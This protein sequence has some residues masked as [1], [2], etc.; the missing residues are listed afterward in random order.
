MTSGWPPGPRNGAHP[1]VV[2]VHG[3]RRPGPDHDADEPVHPPAVHVRL[4]GEACCAAPRSGAGSSCGTDDRSAPERGRAR[5]R[6]DGRRP[7]DAVRTGIG[8]EVRVER[9]VLL[10]DED[11]VLDAR[12]A[13][14]SGDRS[15]DRSPVDTA[16]PG[17]GATADERPGSSATVPPTSRVSPTASTTPRLILP[18]N[19]KGCPSSRNDGAP[20]ANEGP[21]IFDQPASVFNPR[22]ERPPRN[23][24]RS[25]DGDA[26]V[27]F[28][29]ADA[30][31]SMSVPFVRA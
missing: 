12:L 16:G 20:T 29:R 13:M 4:R 26:S 28:D 9:A 6:R 30:V 27:S 15:A 1:G 18:T 11:H 14:L 19:R 22:G 5:R 24:R 31:P 23:G 17:P 3:T 10:D 8:P 25:S 7:S 2:P 21:G